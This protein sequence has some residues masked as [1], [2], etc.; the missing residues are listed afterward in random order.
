MFPEFL[1]SN[2]PTSDA[3]SSPCVNGVDKPSEEGTTISQMLHIENEI[4][5]DIPGYEGAYQASV[6]GKIK[7]LSRNI[8]RGRNGIKVCKEVIKKTRLTKCGY[9]IVGVYKNAI[10]KTCTVHRLIAKTFIPNPDNKPCVNHI[11]AIKTDNR[12]CNL[13]WVTS[14]ENSQHASKLGLY[15][16]TDVGRRKISESSKKKRMP[17]AE[18]SETGQVIRGF[19]SILDCHEET[20]ISSKVI[21]DSCKGKILVIIKRRFVFISLKETPELFP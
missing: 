6:G 13:E 12:A 18:I 11:N 15:V 8:D 10:G 20:G 19:K 16:H 14:S 5:K 3:I 4:W 2:V 9:L 1:Y 21:S 7:S 17:V